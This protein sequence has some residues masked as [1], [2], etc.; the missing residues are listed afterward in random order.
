MIVFGLCM[1][2]CSE[3]NIISVVEGAQLQVYRGIME[4]LTKQSIQD[5]P[6][7]K[8]TTL[9]RTSLHHSGSD[10]EVLGLFTRSNLEMALP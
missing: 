5:S 7:M 3:Q 9:P 8:S 4:M 2:V 6:S 10:K 1:C